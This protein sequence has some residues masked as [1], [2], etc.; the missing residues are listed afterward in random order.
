MNRAFL[1]RA[2]VLA[3]RSVAALLFASIVVAASHD[4]SQAWDSGYYHL[5]F[6]A[7][8]GGVVGADSFAFDAANQA[9]FEGFP[10][11]AE[12]LQGLL[13]RITGRIECA[14]FVAVASVPLFAWFLRRRFDVP[15]SLSMIALFAIPLVQTHATSCYVDLPANAAAS[16]VVLM[17]IEAVAT[18]REI[19]MRAVAVVCACAAIAANMK[20]LLHVI[21]ILA[22]LVIA[23]RLF[24][25][26]DRKKMMVLALALPLIFATPLKNLALHQNPYFPLQL[27]IAGH[28]FPGVEAPY[29]SSPPWLASTPRPVRFVCSILEIGIRPFTDERRWTVD[30]WMPESSGSRMGGF[31]G[32]Y[33]VANLALLVW[34]AA[35]DREG[36]VRRASIAFL[37][38]TLVVSLMPQSHELRYYLSWMMVLV[39]LNAWFIC[40]TDPAEIKLDRPMFGMFATA[41]L[42]FVVA[43]TRADY[44][45]PSG[46][47]LAQLLD[48]KIDEHAV[49]AVPNGAHVCVDRAPWSLY[50]AAPF[51]PPHHYVVQEAETS[52]DCAGAPRL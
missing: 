44:V 52:A 37:A 48:K 24:K 50:Y 6:A 2:S 38:F 28:V 26:G 39:A 33:V 8:L 10:L 29:S 16:V 41:A 3:F 31:F 11:L 19:S 42:L 47:S 36:T 49:A 15:I 4:V 30:Q 14:S 25:R 51:H 5:P 22:L 45:L 17:A 46:S 13:W 1:V 9:R 27:T 32:V 35:R 7:R 18:T 21:L 43:V 20:A 40:R 23:W 34:S 12:L